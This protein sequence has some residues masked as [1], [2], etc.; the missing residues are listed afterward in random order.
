M[1]ETY[2]VPKD[3]QAEARDLQGDLAGRVLGQEPLS[4]HDVMMMRQAW[5]GE[6]GLEWANRI[7]K[8]MTESLLVRADALTMEEKEDEMP[9]MN[10]VPDLQEELTE[11]LA[12]V[13]SFYL[14]AHG[15]HWNVMGPDFAEYHALFAS[16]YDDVYDSIDP[17]AE[18]I[19][20]IGAKAPFKMTD[21]IALRS[22]QD[23]AVDSTDARVLATDLLE[24]NNMIIDGIVEAFECATEC[25]EQGIANFLADRL[26]KHQ[27]W[28]WQLSASLGTDVAPKDLTMVEPAEDVAEEGLTLPLPLAR[29]EENTMIEERKSAIATAERMTMNAEIRSIA[30]DDGSLK[31]GGYA[32]TFN[33]EATGLNFR[34][35]I[36]PGAFTRTL[37]SDN[38]VFLLVNHDTESLPLASTQSGTLTLVEDEI[39]LRMEATLDPS[40]PRAAELASALTRGDVDK[41]SF[42]FTTAPGGE[43]REEGLR[44]LT[45]LNLFEVSV[46]TW[47]AYDSTAVGMRSAE[48][49]DLELRKKLLKAKLT[50]LRLRK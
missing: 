5:Q 45:D 40:N 2:R 8:N 39:G 42:A 12:D 23:N 34:E 29:S 43:T 18:N 31:I 33:A 6:K 13:F 26:D 21:L 32:A 38:P 9:E 44:T 28:R 30:T 50:Q 49:E 47:P 22:I 15:A 19:R 1:T 46:V 14:R 17:L 11:L 20:K 35:V 7:A 10:E 16:I 4:L 3:V 36:A 27:T 41:M 37:K 24:A 48:A 25:N